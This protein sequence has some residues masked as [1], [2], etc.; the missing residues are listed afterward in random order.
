MRDFVYSF[1]KHSSNLHALRY[2]EALDWRG[3]VNVFTKS[4]SD[5]TL[6]EMILLL[7]SKG[8]KF[9]GWVSRFV[10]T[11]KYENIK[12]IPDRLAKTTLCT[13]TRAP[14]D[15]PLEPGNYDGQEHHSLP[16]EDILNSNDDGAPVDSGGQEEAPP[17]PEELRL[18]RK[19][20]AVYQRSMIR[21][22]AA[23]NPT[24]TRLWSLLYDRASSMKLQKHET[25]R[26]LM[27]GPLVHVL[28][29][30]D[31]IKMFADRINKDSKEQLKGDDHRKL[32]ELIDR[33]DRS[34]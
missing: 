16:E 33:S 6:D 15:P 25:Y 18:V 20:E 4:L 31:G 32:E 3:L 9:E 19:V 21:K 11:V 13:D 12:E 29:C 1:V 23:I 27:Q 30:L 10:R 26:L 7:H 2:A 5:S 14:A 17:S 8:P 24:I 28:V 34:R 22:K